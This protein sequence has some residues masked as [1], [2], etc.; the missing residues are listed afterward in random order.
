MSGKVAATILRE[1]SWTDPDALEKAR[2][3]LEG[4]ESGRILGF[5]VAAVM[6]DG[7]TTTGFTTGDGVL[8]LLGALEIVKA[9]MVEWFN[10]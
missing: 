6:K 1:A 10:E 8:K 2:E 5:A 3:L 4:V 7:Y 9:R